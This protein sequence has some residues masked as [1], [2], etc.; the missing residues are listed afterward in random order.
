MHITLLALALAVLCAHA[1][2]AG[3]CIPRGNAEAVNRTWT[4]FQEYHQVLRELAKNAGDPNN[5][6]ATRDALAKASEFGRQFE[7]FSLSPYNTAFSPSLDQMIMFTNANYKEPGKGI[8]AFNEHC[9]WLGGRLFEPEMGQLELIHE[10]VTYQERKKLGTGVRLP[11]YRVKNNLHY[12]SGESADWYATY[13]Y[14]Q[15]DEVSTTKSLGI[16]LITQP[17][18]IYA[19]NESVKDFP[20]ALC[21]LPDGEL[22]L[23]Q[24][25]WAAAMIPELAEADDEASK[26]TDKVQEV[27]GA[28][29][30]G[31]PC[32]EVS[33]ELPSSMTDRRVWA[34]NSAR[35][36]K[37]ATR[38]GSDREY[39]HLRNDISRLATAYHEMRNATVK[40]Q[41]KV[42]SGAITPA[43]LGDWTRMHFDVHEAEEQVILLVSAVALVLL[44]VVATAG[45][46]LC[47]IERKKRVKR[48]L[49]KKYPD[50]NQMPLIERGLLLL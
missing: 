23:K 10:A 37:G 15:R 38:I 21:K 49:L 12:I 48:N 16:G 31:H 36:L 30:N 5:L 17:V 32:E 8:L 2:A 1:E 14:V 29:S 41:E 34:A 11:V 3:T 19:R 4:A 46:H 13:G 6:P 45:I 35:T 28:T 18:K 27:L 25:Q 20:S 40:M 33:V 7:G 22:D 42:R 39:E 44:A 24:S 26:A 9:N 47:N 50:L 43:N